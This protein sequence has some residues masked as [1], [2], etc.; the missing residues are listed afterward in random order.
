MRRLTAGV[1]KLGIVEAGGSEGFSVEWGTCIERE[2]VL[3]RWIWENV[4]ANTVWFPT[5]RST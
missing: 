2:V 5:S 3:L 1:E 4:V